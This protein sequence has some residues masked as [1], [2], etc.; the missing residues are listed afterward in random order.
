MKENVT[1]YERCCKP[2][3]LNYSQLLNSRTRSDQSRIHTRWPPKHFHLLHVFKSTSLGKW[4]VLFYKKLLSFLSASTRIADGCN[5][6]EN[7][8][9]FFSQKPLFWPLEKQRCMKNNP[10][11]WRQTNKQK[12]FLGIYQSNKYSCFGLLCLKKPYKN[13][14]MIKSQSRTKNCTISAEK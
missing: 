7:I 10:A 3:G 11:L 4:V 8:I 14:N 5:K 2:T 1:L 12:Q 13:N 9:F 6:S